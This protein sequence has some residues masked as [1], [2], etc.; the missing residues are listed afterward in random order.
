MAAT[1]KSPTIG[2]VTLE[3]K[4]SDNFAERLSKDTVF[5]NRLNIIDQPGPWTGTVTLYHLDPLVGNSFSRR[6]KPW[7]TAQQ[8]EN[9]EN[10]FETYTEI[11]KAAAPY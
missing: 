3:R 2:N 8:K 5:L 9:V 6:M 4:N 10:M 1:H 11:S 7:I